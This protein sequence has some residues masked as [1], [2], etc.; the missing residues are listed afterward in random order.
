MAE[1]RKDPT[2]PNCKMNPPMFL[3]WWKSQ[4]Q[5]SCTKSMRADFTHKQFAPDPIQRPK[6]DS[7][8]SWHIKSNLIRNLQKH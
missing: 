8:G 4:K 2:L 6:T 5:E 7:K 3:S 1:I